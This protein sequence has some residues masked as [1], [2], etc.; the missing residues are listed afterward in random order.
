MIADYLRLNKSLIY[1]K[2]ADNMLRDLLCQSCHRMLW[3]LNG[4]V[5]CIQES[6]LFK[7]EILRKRTK[8]SCLPSPCKHSIDYTAK[9]SNHSPLPINIT[10][11]KSNTLRL[12]KLREIILCSQQKNIFRMRSIGSACLILKR[13]I[14]FKGQTKWNLLVAQTTTWRMHFSYQR[15]LRLARISIASILPSQAQ[16]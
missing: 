11:R 8:I 12:L 5:Q 15:I 2:N 13:T 6:N 4:K 3:A 9:V 10:L 7:W 14:N 16:N 1:L